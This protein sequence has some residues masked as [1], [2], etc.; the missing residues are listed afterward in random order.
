[1]KRVLFV[2]D[3]PLI[4]EG[5]QN[6]LRGQRKK[7]DM[8]FAVG[9]QAALATLEDQPADVVVS[10]MRMP[11]MDGA[12][13]LARV[14]AMCPQTVRLGLSG[15]SDPAMV[16]RAVPVAHQYLAKPC[17]PRVLEN[18][19]E[20]ALALRAVMD[21][22]T[23][24]GVV[25]RI[26]KLPSIPAV[27]YALSEALAD[28]GAGTGE[29]GRILEQDPAMAAKLLQVANSAF[30][31]GR[32]QITT[33]DSAVTHLGFATVKSLAL[34][35]E[36][37]RMMT[38]SPLL[39]DFS[40]DS[41]QQHAILTQCIV[42]KIVTDRYLREDAATAALLLDIGVL[43]LAAELPE[44]LGAAGTRALVEGRPLHEVEG[45]EYETSH[46][47]VGAYLLGIWGLPYPIVEA[48]A[49]HHAPQRVRQP[50]FDI[51]AAAYVAD[52][53][54]ME[55]NPSSTQGFYHRPSE[56]DLRYLSELGV[57]AHLGEWRAMAS[58][59]AQRASEG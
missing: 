18:V 32:R 41:L 5:L 6:A 38:P 57:D 44:A 43:A 12:E 39:K 27:Y 35:V 50:G 4:L 53:L 8:E 47:E 59:E 24:R 10:D 46:A 37:F 52:S 23:V 2:D 30:F 56:V 1:M 9:G 51:L 25:G 33:V 22:E 3:E 48:V 29:V 58:E 45:D 49:N 7:W 31:R 34:S 54:A 55:A 14:K 17:E 36:V 21:H 42:R 26:D 15:Y 11:G 28:P 19:V 40:L 13:F 20:R 16:H